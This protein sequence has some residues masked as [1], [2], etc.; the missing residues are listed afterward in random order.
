[1]NLDYLNLNSVRN[2]PIIDDVSRASDD[3]LFVIPN[4]LIVDMALC[5]SQLGDTPNLYIS[6]VTCNSSTIL[7]EISANSFGVFGTFQTS[8]P[9]SD[10]NVDISLQPSSLFPNAS[11][12][13]TLGSSDDLATLPYGNFTFSYPNTALLMKVFTPTISTISW[14]NFTD[15]KGNNTLTGYI[16][17]VGNNNVQFRGAFS[18]VYLD[19]GEN[20]GL[21]KICVTPPQAILT[22]NGVPP[23]S[24]GNFTFIADTCISI[25]TAQYGLVLSNPCGA[26]CLGCEA[27]TTLTTQVNSLETSIVDLKTFTD[28]LQAVITQ[29]T[30]MIS[31]PCQCS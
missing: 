4:S 10:Y 14:L 2:F 20:L 24:T 16:N 31:I 5:S 19:A 9:L 26:P 29:A 1:M 15:T 23:S 8:L 25:D 12:L 18:N 6:R 3:G 17:L 21:N 13:I 28:N 27:L 30:N 11:G 7:I 22:I